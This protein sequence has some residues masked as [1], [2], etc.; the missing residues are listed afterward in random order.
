MFDL[1]YSVQVFITTRAPW[2]SLIRAAGQR[3]TAAR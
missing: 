1:A 3:V 2:R